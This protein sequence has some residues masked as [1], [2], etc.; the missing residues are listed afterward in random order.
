MEHRISHQ[1]MDELLKQ[2]EDDYVKAVKG[3]ESTTVEGFI[4]QF[5]YDSWDYNDRNIENIKSVLS[6]YTSGEIYKGTF[7]GAFNEMIDHL[8]VKLEQLDPDMGYPV[9]HS[10]H[11]A[12]VLVAFVDGLV[13]QYY[14]GTYDVDQLRE[15]TPY[16]KRIILQALQ[17]ES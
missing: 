4:E 14:I 13:I 1:G 12:S 9:L 11:G 2:L 15:M 6:R 16:F 17:T 10:N 3:N 5:L 8:Q 7:S